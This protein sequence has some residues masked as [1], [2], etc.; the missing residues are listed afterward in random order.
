MKALVDEAKRR[1]VAPPKLPGVGRTVYYHR[2][3]PFPH[4]FRRSVRGARRRFDERDLE[5]AA[6]RVDPELGL[7]PPVRYRYEC[8]VCGAVYPRRRRVRD[9]S[10]SRCAPRFDP[11]FRLRLREARPL[12]EPT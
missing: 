10:C 8:P 3:R 6:L 11:R 7:P 5:V 4:P 9:V 2:L 12:R 1:G